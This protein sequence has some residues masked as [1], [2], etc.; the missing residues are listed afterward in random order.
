MLFVGVSAAL[1]S[2]DS[3]LDRP[4][5]PINLIPQQLST[6]SYSKII[7][8]D[9]EIIFKTFT[10]F[11]NY[12][13]VL[14][15]NIL[16]VNNIPERKSAYDIFLIEKGIKTKLT[17][18][19]ILEP[20]Y[21]QIIKVIDGDAQGTT[22]IQTFESYG[23]GT[24]ILIEIDLKTRGILVPFSFLPQ[25]NVNHAI[26]TIVTTFVDYSKRSYNQNEKIIDNLYR[27]I[28][29]RPVDS[30]GLV[31]FSTLLDEGKFT[32]DEIRS[33]LLNSEEYRLKILLN[34]LKEISDLSDDTKNTLDEFYDIVLR[35]NAD[36]T[37]LQY[38]GSALENDKMTLSEII[39]ALLTSDEF[40]SLPVETR[41]MNETYRSNESWQIVNQ[42]YYEIHD[43][44]PNKKTVRAY[45]IF[46][47]N[48]EISLD[49]IKK[50]MK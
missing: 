22:I 17:V 4:F 6:I 25:Q 46:F 21:K 14:P 42:T 28:L 48:G 31:R 47:E 34:D 24:K 40:Y 13:Y 32:V 30:Q 38:F 1:I 5:G 11:E 33:K 50:L 16:S 27:E 23:N 26:D 9:R 44:Y 19:F 20:Y 3:S 8:V 29:L 35:R 37:G 45:G 36:V 10:D 41:D 18:E 12:P 2:I 49:E 7:N 15:N 43:K 39:N